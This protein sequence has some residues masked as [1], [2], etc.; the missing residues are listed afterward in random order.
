MSDEG[1]L[2][3]REWRQE[4]AMTSA[5]TPRYLIMTVGGVGLL[6]L[7]ATMGSLPLDPVTG[8]ICATLLLVAVGGRVLLGKRHERTRASVA[9]DL[10][11]GRVIFRNCAFVRDFAR[12]PLIGEKVIPFAG[13]F[14]VRSST[15][16]NNRFMEIE[17]EEGMVTLANVV[18]DDS[19]VDALGA[20]VAANRENDPEFA[21]RHAVMPRPR[22]AWWGW[23]ILL[24]A[25]GAVMWFGWKFM[26]S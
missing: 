24:G 3:I 21:Q 2:A 23:L 11:A 16:K 14:A 12:N 5:L 17:T 6:Y 18:E 7:G 10:E 20:I 1:G 19:L 25:I 13:L 22:T 15:V 26:Y 9:I 8:A 4:V